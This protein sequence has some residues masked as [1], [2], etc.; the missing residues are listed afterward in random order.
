MFDGEPRLHANPWDLQH[1]PG[2]ISHACVPFHVATSVRVLES[3][4]L[5]FRSVTTTRYRLRCATT[6]KLQNITGAQENRMENIHGKY[7]TSMDTDSDIA[8]ATK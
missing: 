7:G 6:A 5:S 8:D 1:K 4:A 2:A 3:E